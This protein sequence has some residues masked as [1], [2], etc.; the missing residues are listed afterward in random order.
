MIAVTG[1]NGKTTTLCMLNEVL[2]QAGFTTA[3]FTTAVIELAGKSRAND[4]NVTVPTTRALL[5][6]LADANETKVDYVLLEVTSQA[7]DQFKIPRLDLEVAIF[8]NL[9]QDHLDYHKDMDS[10]AFAKS[11][12]WQMNP[13][14]SVVNTDSDWFDYFAQFNPGERLLTYG[15]KM[16]ATVRIAKAEL[17]RQ[18][19]DVV[20]KYDNKPI[21]I[22]T[23]LPGQFNVYNA[24]AASTT[25]LALGIDTDTIASGIAALE[26]LP[27]RQERIEND[28]DIDILVDYAH[29][30]DAFEKLLDFARATSKNR[31]IIVFGATGDRDRDKRPVMG[32]IAAE[33]ADQLFVT[34]EENYTEDAAQIRQMILEG[35]KE[36]D[37][38]LTKTI[39]IAD[40][41]EAIEKA[42]ESAQPGGMILV[43][44]MGHEQYRIVDGKR[45]PWNDTEVIKEILAK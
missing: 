26:M 24:T 25:A 12:L 5:Q 10:Y 16:S 37:S 18:G 35:V 9:T 30:P 20:L 28:R 33:K 1:T 29:T 23:P 13:K 21:E 43:T 3:M 11:K 4:L 31:V 45:I 8:T 15:T 40:R 22:G 6:F 44:G 42:L 14:F 36:V 7:L 32:R 2:K 41:R 17:Y 38:E 34:D 19:S 39:E 27:G